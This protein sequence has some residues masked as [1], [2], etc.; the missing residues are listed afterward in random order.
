MLKLS[1]VKKL[2]KQETYKMFPIMWIKNKNDEYYNS[3][4]NDVR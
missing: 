1:K 2:K 4:E 3:I